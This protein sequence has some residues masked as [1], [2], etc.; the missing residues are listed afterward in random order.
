ML[1]IGCFY[2]ICFSVDP[3]L[4]G[5]LEKELKTLYDGVETFLLFIGYGRSGHSLIAAILD[6]HPEILV[7]NEHNV[8]GN[9]ENYKARSKGDHNL[10]KKRL[11][12][13][14]HSHSRSQALFGNR[15]G[16]FCPAGGYCYHVPGQWQGTYKDKIKVP[17]NILYYISQLVRTL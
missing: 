8:L 14:L 1:K 6:A 13:D 9:W 16:P 15:A 7:V 17:N 5:V 3:H 10:L 12:F 11:F 4:L 2:S